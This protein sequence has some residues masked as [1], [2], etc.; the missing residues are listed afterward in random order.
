[1]CVS[2][3]HKN[4]IQ[5]LFPCIV[6]RDIHMNKIGTIFH[7]TRKLVVVVALD[8]R[9]VCRRRC[10]CGCFMILSC[11]VTTHTALSQEQRQ[12]GL[13]CVLGLEEETK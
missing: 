5:A 2:R 12:H 8:L 11:V 13:V 7:K 6:K 9:R 10:C 1:M 3:G 4:E